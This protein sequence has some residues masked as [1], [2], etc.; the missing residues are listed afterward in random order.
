MGVCP[1][2]IEMIDADAATALALSLPEAA[3]SSHFGN[4]DFRVRDRIF[5]SMPK[6]GAMV[7][8]LTPEQQ[9]MLIEAE[10]AVFSALPN[11]WGEKGWTTALLAT[12]D[13]PTALSALWMAW[14]NVAPKALAKLA[15]VRRR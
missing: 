2:G 1:W 11:K 5:A 10:G 14:G 6:A 15:K 9:E 13:E 8:K 12:L 7:L 3:Q 4:T